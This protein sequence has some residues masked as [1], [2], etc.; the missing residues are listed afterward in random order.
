M[1]YIY[2][3]YRYINYMLITINYI[4][5]L[6]INLQVY[7]LKINELLKRRQKRYVY[8]VLYTVYINV[9]RMLIK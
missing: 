6:Y 2:N 4:H 5:R 9:T 1:Y 8:Y 7:F 3:I